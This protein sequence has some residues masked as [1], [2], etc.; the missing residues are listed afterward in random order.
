M[1]A[2]CGGT[3]PAANPGPNAGQTN[4]NTGTNNAGKTT[5]APGGNTPVVPGATVP[6]ATVSAV[7]APKE[8]FG[9]V[10]M[11][12][13]ALRSNAD[14]KP[15][16]DLLMKEGEDF[17]KEFDF[18]ALDEIQMAICPPGEGEFAPVAP[19]VVMTFKDPAA[20]TATIAKFRDLKPA[21]HAGKKYQSHANPNEPSIYQ[22]NPNVVVA[23]PDRLL[24]SF[25][26]SSTPPKALADAMARPGMT[27]QLRLV[28]VPTSQ[29]E[30][31]G[32]MA[33]S[34]NL[35]FVP[36]P[37]KR[38]LDLPQFVTLTALSLHVSGD[39][40]LHLELDTAA[41]GDTKEVKDR[42]D[43]AL[44][45]AKE[46]VNEVLLANLEND[47]GA[48]PEA[49]EMAKPLSEETL[50]KLKVSVEGTKVVL[51]LPVSPAL[52]AMAR[53]SV[54]LALK[55]AE[56]AKQANLKLRD[57]NNLKQIGLGALNY[58]NSTRKLPD[59]FRSADGKAILSWRVAILPYC[60]DT[61][62]FEKLDKMMPW[63]AAP[64]RAAAGT[65]PGV[66][67]ENAT[68]AKNDGIP[69]SRIFRFVGPGT[70]FDGPK[71]VGFGDIKDGASNTILYVQAG[72]SKAV[73]WTQ[74]ADLTFDAKD[75]IKALGDIPP[76]GFLAV[77]CDGSARIIPPTIKP[78]QLAALITPAGN[79]PV[80]AP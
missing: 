79:E 6:A 22:P 44:N 11:K 59:D 73:P 72:P 30:L 23:A 33:K 37:V 18:L 24:K 1:A 52:A 8:A 69:T 9:L 38:L 55:A 4:T 43:A 53:K 34:P 46:M 25:L 62:I 75:P 71:P 3:K 20:A 51:S 47:P 15:I 63:D 41:A 17:R 32:A 36:P 19:C 31:V 57:M 2:G 21:E 35:A 27:G 26:D 40:F 42:L 77:F 68:T 65:L 78:E 10:V 39:E 80:D 70:L 67:R 45:F 50:G 49:K 74:P 29:R 16:V 60:E 12:A 48:P 28:V 7:Q 13:E 76:T 61:L 54:P 5:P 66:F 64:N 58:E 56:Q 14:L